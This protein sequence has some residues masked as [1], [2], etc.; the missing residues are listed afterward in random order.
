M[1]ATGWA[2]RS[3]RQ[4]APGGSELTL[5]SSTS[6]ITWTPGLMKVAQPDKARPSAAR[7]GPEKGRMDIPLAGDA[8][9]SY[10]DSFCA[11]RN[12]RPRQRIPPRARSGKS[13]IAADRGFARESAPILIT[14]DRRSTTSVL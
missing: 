3:I 9:P 12:R 11:K 7:G 10:L 4:D 1:I 13:V 6:V 14:T 2:I 8:T 5:T